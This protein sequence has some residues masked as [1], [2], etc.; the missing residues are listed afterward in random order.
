MSPLLRLPTELRLQ[1][2]HYVIDDHFASRAMWNSDVDGDDGVLN[3]YIIYERSQL[4]PNLLNAHMTFFEECLPIVLSKYRFEFD[5]SDVL[6]NLHKKEQFVRRKV[7]VPIDDQFVEFSKFLEPSNLDCWPC[8]RSLEDELKKLRDLLPRAEAIYAAFNIDCI[9]CSSHS[10]TYHERRRQLKWQHW[11]GKLKE[12]KMPPGCGITDEMW[13]ERHGEGVRERT[14]IELKFSRP[15]SS[16]MHRHLQ[17][18]TT[19]K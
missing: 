6:L 9:E 4:Y 12:A 14:F 16:I 17:F 1:I 19:L 2:Y 10:H 8:K 18:R 5:H 13:E 11:M 15:G 3:M 7:A